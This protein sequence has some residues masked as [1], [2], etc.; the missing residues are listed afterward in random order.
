MYS[1]RISAHVRAER[2]AVYRALLDPDALVRWRVP[3][4][5]SGQVHVFE[6]REGGAFRV[7]LSYDAPDGVGKSAPHTDT[8]HGHFVR[9]VPGEQVV[10]VLEFETEDPA[11][12]GVMTMTTTL[13]DVDAG[14][15]VLVVH[16]G[17]PDGIAAADNETGTRMA[18]A[19]LARLVE[20]GEIRR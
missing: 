4:G 7:S 6:A 18:L 15:E 3:D 16:D 5:M 20:A 10:E 2:A 13:T 12:R 11:L 17:I 8:Y 14:T 1:T 19:N 9:L